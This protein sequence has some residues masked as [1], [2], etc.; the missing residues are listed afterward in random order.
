MAV[1]EKLVKFRKAKNLTQKEV[2]SQLKIA[3]STF[4]NYERGTR[5]PSPELI[6]SFARALNLSDDEKLELM[7][8]RDINDPNEPYTTKPFDRQNFMILEPEKLK[9]LPPTELIKI[10][11]YAEMVYDYYQLTKKR[12]SKRI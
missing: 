10:K 8:D 9:Q 4:S 3:E 12:R 11:E 5:I 1:N 2:A 6:H 7:F